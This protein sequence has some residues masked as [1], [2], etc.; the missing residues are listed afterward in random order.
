MW[1]IEDQ[2]IGLLEGVRA[3]LSDAPAFLLLT[4]HTPGFGPVL[5]SS[6]LR[7]VFGGGLLPEAEE[8]ALT[9]RAG[10]RLPAGAS[11]RLAFS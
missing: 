9:D 8:M 2:V 4:A 7:E 5:L 1:K 3:L 11:A 6:L 10:R